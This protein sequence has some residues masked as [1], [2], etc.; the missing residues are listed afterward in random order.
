M[1]EEEA[2]HC[3]TRGPQSRSLRRG[4]GHKECYERSKAV[5]LAFLELIKVFPVP[6]KLD[7]KLE[8]RHPDPATLYTSRTLNRL[9]VR[10]TPPPAAEGAL[11]GEHR[12]SAR[13][14][15]LFEGPGARTSSSPSTRYSSC[16][17]LR[18]TARKRLDQRRL[19][20][21]DGEVLG[22]HLRFSSGFFEVEVNRNR[23]TPSR[24]PDQVLREA[25]RLSSTVFTA[26]R[27]AP[28]PRRQRNQPGRGLGTS[29]RSTSTKTYG[30]VLHQ[31]DITEDISKN[32]IIPHLS[33]R[34]GRDVHRVAPTMTGRASIDSLHPSAFILP[35]RRSR[36]TPTAR[37]PA[38]GHGITC[39]LRPDG[40][41]TTNAV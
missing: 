6:V 18:S 16:T 37:H 4:Q 23:S 41:R 10:C 2:L 38:V 13:R 5:A 9:D 32:T 8:S 14:A 11:D 26:P 21:T 34:R 19:D 7:G 24:I 12:R 20:S 39:V 33:T 31:E 25:L 27:R 30:D 36:T 40:P 28:L 22:K 1:Q 3:P 15:R 17:L 35:R 29:S